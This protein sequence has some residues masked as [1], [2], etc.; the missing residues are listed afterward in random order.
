MIRD[1]FVPLTGTPGD[2]KAVAAAIRMASTLE[3]HI[4]VAQTVNMPL[5]T[6]EP[7]GMLPNVTEM[8]SALRSDAQ[9]T[10]EQHRTVLEREG[11]SH[12]LRLAESLFLEPPDTFALHARYAD[13]SVLVGPD[14]EIG[15]ESTILRRFFAA[16]L[17]QSGRPVMVVPR[18][19]AF[20]WPLER[21]MVAWSPTRECTHALH[22]AIS[23]LSNA[24]AVDVVTIEPDVGEFGHGDWP[25]ADI[26]THLA[27]HGLAVNVLTLPRQGQ[28]VSTALLSHAAESGAQLLIAGG[29]G[30]SRLREWMLGGA[31]GELLDSARLPLLFA[32]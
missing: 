12:E 18:N 31:T 1:L 30:H 26:G 28:T 16:L 22:E 20:Q 24:A 9:S 8:Y 17:F 15:R 29:Y 7:W 27:R 4:T 25:G 5:P 6:I 19:H 23:L 2:Q 3:A 21:A 13:L 10:L 11:V 32:H 14:G